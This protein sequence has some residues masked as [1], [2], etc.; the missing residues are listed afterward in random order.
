MSNLI[1]EIE[2]LLNQNEH[3]EMLFEKAREVRSQHF[4]NEVFAYGFD[5]F[6]TYCAKSCA[7]CHYRSDNKGALRYRADT[8]EVVDAALRLV[9]SGVHLIDLTMGEDPYYTRTPENLANL[10]DRVHS[11]TGL[12]VM[13]SPG[14]VR[15]EYLRLYKEAGAAWFALYQETF[16]P[17]S[18]ARLRTSQ[19]YEERIRLKEEAL[20]AGLLIE[21]GLLTGWGDSA[22]E[23]ALSLVRMGQLSPSQVRVMT[24]VPQQGTP[25][26]GFAPQTHERELTMIALM[27]LLFPDRLIPASLDVEGL[28]GLE[29]RLNAGANVI[30][31]IIPPNSGLVGVSRRGDIDDGGRSLSQVLPILERTGLRLAPL[32]RYQ[33]FLESE[34]TRSGDT[35]RSRITFPNRGEA[36]LAIG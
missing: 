20:K 17:V 11:A 7:F 22:K 1:H 34:A 16:D 30:T 24:F 21:E 36:L 6:S 31:S 8:E 5:Y 18:Y 28:E 23:A 9:N 35:G 19:S 15:P 13:I 12:P 29:A 25:M 26:E 10:I 4:D 2:F 3:K 14:V 33:A 27:R 32:S